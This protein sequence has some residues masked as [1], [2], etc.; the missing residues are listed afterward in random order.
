MYHKTYHN[1]KDSASDS[2]NEYSKVTIFSTSF[3]QCK[4]NIPVLIFGAM[5]L[6]H[7]YPRS[8]KSQGIIF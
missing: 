3:A 4:K 6:H 8:I 1:H 7:I 5:I 2:K